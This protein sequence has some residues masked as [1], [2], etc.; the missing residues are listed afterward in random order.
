[1]EPSQI[2]I[3]NTYN[4][5]IHIY[6]YTYVTNYICTYI[7]TYYIICNHIIYNIYDTLSSIY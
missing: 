5:Y 2:I 6:I 4:I 7:I 1:M 3:Y